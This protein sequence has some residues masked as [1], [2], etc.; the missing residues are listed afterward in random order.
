MIP[1]SFI[2]VS[3]LQSKAASLLQQESIIEPA[4]RLQ[5]LRD[6]DTLTRFDRDVSTD[7]L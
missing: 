1:N 6:R 5:S 7:E 2:I 4:S 3:S